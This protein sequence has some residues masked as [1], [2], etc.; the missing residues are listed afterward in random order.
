MSGKGTR[1]ALI[2]WQVLRRL[3]QPLSTLAGPCLFP[4]L[5]LCVVSLAFGTVVRP[6]LDGMSYPAYLVPLALLNIVLFGGIAEGTDAWREAETAIVR[7]LGTFD[8]GQ[9]AVAASR[10]TAYGAVVAVQ[11]AVL[12]V[13]LGAATGLALPVP[14]VLATMLLMAAFGAGIGAFAAGLGLRARAADDVPGVFHALFLP[15]TFLSTG[16]VPLSLFPGGIQWLVRLNPLSWLAQTSRALLD[17]TRPPSAELAGAVGAAAGLCLLG[18]LLV[19]R[20][21]AEA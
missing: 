9:V 6:Y 12:A 7:R 18:L 19:Y 10:A 4:L 2:R 20:A 15:L 14:G 5:S 11:A 17:G 3:R 21:G 1:G 13:A 16:Y 8:V